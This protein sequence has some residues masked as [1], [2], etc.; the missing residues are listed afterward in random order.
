VDHPSLTS[1]LHEAEERLQAAMLAGDVRELDRLLD[2][3][4][5]YT[6]PDGRCITKQDDLQAHRSGT[7]TLNR[8]TQEELALTVAGSTGVTRILAVLEGT[9]SGAP[10][11]ARLRYTRTWTRDDRGWRVLAAHASSA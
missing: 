2:D 3:R 11:A 5:V 10:F 9:A 7:L 8:L 6:G 4:V 1:D